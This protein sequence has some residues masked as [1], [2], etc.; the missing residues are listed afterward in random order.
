MN[1]VLRLLVC[2]MA[3]LCLAGPAAAASLRVSPVTLALT[4]PAA[5]TSLRVWNDG[6]QPINVQVRV[7]RWTQR[8][9]ED[10]LEPAA[11]VAVSPPITSLQPGSAQVVRVVRVSTEAVVREESYRLLIDE[12]PNPFQPQGAGI[13]LV[14]RHS[15]P[16]FLSPAASTA[17]LSWEFTQ[18]EG[19]YVVA[20]RND[21]TAHGKIANLSLVGP[22]GELLAVRVGLVGYVVP[23]S[24]MRWFFPSTAFLP[25]GSVI[26]ITA[27]G[28]T[29][30]ID[31]S[32]RLQGG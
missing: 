1:V 6:D 19:G 27:D 31:A 22:S 15:I 4:A 32:A 11:D 2:A 8:N 7:F 29:E 13:N 25:A 18:A 30:P 24:V 28:E 3:A 12:L 9:G 16:V 5:A 23:N 26:S 14:V 21:G 20:A 17:A 10:V